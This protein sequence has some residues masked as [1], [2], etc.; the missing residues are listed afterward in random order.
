MSLEY[1][2]IY[3]EKGLCRKDEEP[4]Y[5]NHCAFGPCSSETPSRADLIRRMDDPELARYLF[6]VIYR[7][8]ELEFCKGKPECEELVDT[9]GGVPEENC[10]ACL[11]EYLKNP[12]EKT[13]VCQTALTEEQTPAI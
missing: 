11:V 2:C 12:E 8:F 13:T 1:A 6:A 7:D 10:I 4:G 5:T 9:D 3:H